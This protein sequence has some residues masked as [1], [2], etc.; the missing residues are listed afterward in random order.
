MKNFFKHLIGFLLIYAPIRAIIEV[1]TGGN[2]TDLLTV[3]QL[4]GASIT[5]FLVAGFMAHQDKNK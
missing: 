5:A 4:L 3:Q 1:T 2:L